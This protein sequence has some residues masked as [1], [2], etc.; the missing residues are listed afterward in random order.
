MA[1]EDVQNA[2]LAGGVAIGAVAD[3]HCTPAGALAIGLIAAT[4]SCF[5]FRYINPWLARNGLYDTCGIHNLHGMPG[6][7]GGLASV[8]VTAVA[9]PATYGADYLVLMPHGATQW[10]HQLAAIAVTLSLA[11]VSGTIFGLIAMMLPMPTTVFH[12]SETWEV[13]AALRGQEMPRKLD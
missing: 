2:T 13:P 7:I 4:V 3:L 8:V 10:G 12:D 9:T 11:L 6:L 5:G 1:M